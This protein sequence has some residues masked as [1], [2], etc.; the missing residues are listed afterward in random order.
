MFNVLIFPFFHRNKILGQLL[1]LETSEQ[2][3]MK[4]GKDWANSPVPVQ[5]NSLPQATET[6]IIERDIKAL[7]KMVREKKMECFAL[8]EKR[9]AKDLLLQNTKVAILQKLQAKN[10][11]KSDELQRIRMNVATANKLV[12]LAKLLSIS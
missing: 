1:A 3:I 9:V 5:D 12:S 11:V 6:D 8:K 10:K 2:H 4:R 7:T